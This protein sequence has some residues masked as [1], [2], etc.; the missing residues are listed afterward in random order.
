MVDSHLGPQISEEPIRSPIS[1]ATCKDSLNVEDSHPKYGTLDPLT[2]M[3]LSRTLTPDTSIAV[4]EYLIFDCSALSYVDLSGTKVLTSLYNDT[5]KRGITLIFVNC[6]E[7]LMQQL[8]RCN[9]FQ[10]FPKS[11]IYPSII[12]AVMTLERSMTANSFESPGV[13]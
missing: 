1:S 9:Y 3:P 11:L 6:S 12:D 8:D 2:S 4:I 10:T 13:P 7:P 5:M